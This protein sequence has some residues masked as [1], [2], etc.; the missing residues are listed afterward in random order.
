MIIVAEKACILTLLPYATMP[1]TMAAFSWKK[2][3]QGQK[4]ILWTW[5]AE[6]QRKTEWIALFKKKKKKP[7]LLFIAISVPSVVLWGSSG[8]RIPSIPIHPYPESI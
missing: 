7:F 5:C 1:A 3:G 4:T 2:V 6:K 8:I